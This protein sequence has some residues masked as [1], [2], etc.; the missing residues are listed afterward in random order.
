MITTIRLDSEIR[1]RLK[2]LGI[3]GETYQE[4]IIKLMDSKE[5]KK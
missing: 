2:R 3:K 1:D 5:N 4:I